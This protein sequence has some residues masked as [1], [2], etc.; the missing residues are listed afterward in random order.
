MAKSTV[1]LGKRVAEMKFFD[2]AR[3]I[4]STPHGEGIFYGITY[5]RTTDAAALARVSFNDR[6]QLIRLADVKVVRAEVIP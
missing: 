4:V 2:D 5:S 6:V 1:N 3:I